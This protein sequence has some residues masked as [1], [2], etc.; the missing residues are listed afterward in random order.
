MV[1]VHPFV[2]QGN[3]KECRKV[4]ARL[5]RK[6]HITTSASSGYLFVLSSEFLENIL[7]AP[8]SV[9]CNCQ[10]YTDARESKSTRKK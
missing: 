5:R 7:V 6:T 9:R 3:R 2:T 1:I 4:Y 8:E 10:Q